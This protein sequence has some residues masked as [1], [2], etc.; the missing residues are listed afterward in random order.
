[1]ISMPRKSNQTILLG[2]LVLCIAVFSVNLVAAQDV[3][4]LPEGF[5]LATPVEFPA[6][7]DVTIYV[8]QANPNA[9]DTGLGTQDEPKLTIDVAL[10]E[11]V[12]NRRNGLSTRILLAAGT[13]R[14]DLRYNGAQEAKPGAPI[15]IE[16]IEPGAVT[17]SAADIFTEWERVDEDQPIYTHFWEY[18]WGPFDNPWGDEPNAYMAP[19]TRRREAVF[20]DEQP[21]RQVLTRQEMTPGTFYVS[22]A[23]DLL[24]IWLED[25]IDLNAVQVDVP[26]RESFLFLD[27]TDN[28]ALRGLRFTYAASLP[29]G[30]PLFIR[31]SQNILIE[32]SEF[33]YS[34]WAGFFLRRVENVTIL[35][36]IA[37]YNGIRGMGAFNA[38]NLYV[39]NVDNLYNNWRGA[40]GGFNGWDAGQ[41]FLVIYRG[42]F[43]NYRAEHNEGAGLWL[44]FDNQHIL[45][46]NATICDNYPMG[47]FIEA[48]PGPVVIR[49]SVICENRA[50]GRDF[51]NAG[52]FSTNSEQI[53][54]EN[55]RIYGNEFGQIRLLEPSRFRPVTDN[56]TGEVRELE[57]LNWTVRNN[58]IATTRSDQY[59]ID[60]PGGG[61]TSWDEMIVLEENRY[62]DVNQPGV[63]HI[64]NERF[65]FEQWQELVSD[66]SVPAEFGVEDADILASLEQNAELGIVGQYFR[67]PNF[68]ERVYTRV[69]SNV[70]FDWFNSGP[71]EIQDDGY[72]IVWEGTLIPVE[73]GVHEFWVRSTD[74]MAFYFEG[75]LAAEQLQ[76]SDDDLESVFVTELVAGQSYDVRVEYIDPEG[77]A[78]VHLLWSYGRTP[79]QIIPSRYFSVTGSLPE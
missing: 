57:L 60:I 32:D 77:V 62:Y 4:G 37:N 27:D 46:E 24:T 64:G 52:I 54:L 29:G 75:Q 63:F 34:N 58:V 71:P 51:G 50:Q 47:V 2:L 16:A 3:D 76:V 5:Q 7:T 19:I 53:I 55:N 22:E 1:M 18:D 73:S 26:V 33:L 66:T 15:I 20:I 59:L 44:D 45:V 72:S 31:D 23:N 41:K 38:K 30:G 17:L 69:D 79:K 70:N 9:S 12:D 25:D 43:R 8:D 67:N 61:R 39:E 40:L 13:Y 42:V 36:S 68:T 28:I 6:V 35:N 11:A 65:N 21:L 56:T 49:D 78:H 48:S 14:E 74:P 10:R